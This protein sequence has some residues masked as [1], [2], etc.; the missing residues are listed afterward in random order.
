MMERWLKENKSH[1]DL[2]SLLLRYLRGRGSTTCS[3]CSKALNLPHIIQEFATSQDVIGW[4]G[5]IMGMV[6]SKFLPIQSAYL[7]ECNS[8]NLIEWWIFG[9]ITQLLQVTHSQWIYWCILVHD[10]TTGTLILAHK[11]ELLI[12]I[13]HQLLLE[14]K[15][16]AEEDQFLLE[17]NFDERMSMTG[18][19]QEYWLLAIKAAW[20]ASR[21]HAKAEDSQQQCSS[22]DTT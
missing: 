20:E 9:V 16:L 3:K 6:S 1:P 19:H 8:S 21:L 11:D 7:L 10:C 12:E 18:K 14:S 17:C 15:G 4:D 13:K 22:A 2:Q 5:F